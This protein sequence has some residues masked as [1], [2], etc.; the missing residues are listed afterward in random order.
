MVKIS[1]ESLFEG[2]VNESFCLFVFTYP[3][4]CETEFS[5]I[6]CWENTE[7]KTKS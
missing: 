2:N 1:T 3:G 4:I 6:I 5:E 7:Q